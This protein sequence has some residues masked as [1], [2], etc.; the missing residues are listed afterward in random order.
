MASDKNT[1]IKTLETRS[2]RVVDSQSINSFERSLAAVKVTQ[3]DVFSNLK[4]DIEEVKK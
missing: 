4:C 3:Q 2:T 1:T